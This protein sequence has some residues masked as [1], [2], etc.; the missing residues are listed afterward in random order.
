MNI[1]LRPA[2]CIIP[3]SLAL[4]FSCSQLPSN[5]SPEKPAAA[6]AD[7]P[8]K[9]SKE[10]ITAL[11]EKTWLLGGIL[12]DAGFIPLEPGHGSDARMLLH[13]DGTMEGSTGTNL[14]SGTWHSS[15]KSA[16]SGLITFKIVKT[17]RMAAP[18]EIAAAFETR[19]LRH[20]QEIRAFKTGKDSVQ[21]RGESD[22]VLLKWIH[23]GDSAF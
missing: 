14:F 12:L 4:F 11:S 20:L 1:R 5:K 18:N 23:R 7:K 21:F 13:P 6:R 19:F 10:S 8:A 15:S 3:L 16:E 2:L 9:S 17:T 22:T